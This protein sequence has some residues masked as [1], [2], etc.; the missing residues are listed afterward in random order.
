MTTVDI[1]FTIYNVS[2]GSQVGH[3]A[4]LAEIDLRPQAC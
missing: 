2:I 1:K 4:L 3:C